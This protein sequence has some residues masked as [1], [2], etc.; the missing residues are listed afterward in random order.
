MTDA[1]IHA[2]AEDAAHLLDALKD[3]EFNFPHCAEMVT[4]AMPAIVAA[5]TWPGKS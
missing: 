4:A 3:Q 5:N 2:I 1:E